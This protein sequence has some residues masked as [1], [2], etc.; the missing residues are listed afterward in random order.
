ME[1]GESDLATLLESMQP[2]L[3]PDTYVFTTL[4]AQDK[5][6][7]QLEDK[8]V[9]TFQEKEGKTF[10]L[11]I[12]V[13]ETLGYQFEFPCR[14]ITLKVHSSLGAVGFLAVILKRLA[15]EGIPCNVASGFYHD[16]LF[17][18]VDKEGDAMEILNNISVGLT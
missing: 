17:V 5:P 2:T 6:P 3:M 11:P 9:F 15:Q 1:Q 4:T 10:V 18:P 14:M 7:K 12:N 8:S 16:H 13:V